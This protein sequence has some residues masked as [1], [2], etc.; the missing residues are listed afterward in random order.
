MITREVPDAYRA[1][2]EQC[3]KATLNFARNINDR[4]K[5][6]TNNLLQQPGSGIQ[7]VG[8][9]HTQALL[10]MLTASCN[11]QADQGRSNTSTPSSP[12]SAK[13]L[14]K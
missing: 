1:E 11:Q 10:E 4:N 2:A 14:V 3:A 8:S 6:I 7:I 9:A 12:N 5:V 13:I